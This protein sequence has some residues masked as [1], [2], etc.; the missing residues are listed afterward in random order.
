MLELGSSGSRF[1]AVDITYCGWR[2][3]IPLR[4]FGEIRRMA[5]LSPAV[6]PSSAIRLPG[7]IGCMR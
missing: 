3:V 5:L 4:V 2:G 6:Q 7:L 1:L